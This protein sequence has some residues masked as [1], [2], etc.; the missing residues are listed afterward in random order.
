MEA[1][2]NENDPY[3]VR[4]LGNL[5]SG[6]HIANGRVDGRSIGEVGGE[7]VGG[8]QAHFFAGIGV[9][10]YALRL[11]GVPDDFPVWTGSCPCQ[12]FSCAGRGLGVSDERHLWPEW[13]RL[14]RKCRPSLVFGEQVA[15]KDGLA[16]LDS[17]HD[18][19]E[20]EGYAVGAA[21]LCAPGVG[22]PHKRSRI[23]FVAH[24]NLKGG[25]GLVALGGACEARPWGRFGEA[26]LQRLIDAPTRNGD[27]WP[28][29]IIRKVDDGPSKR[30]GRLH[31]YGNSIVAP[32]AAEFIRASIEAIDSLT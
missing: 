19:L 31:A 5:V 25:K 15:S 30:V 23:Y 27:L 17:V 4:W 32:L 28:Q 13:F 14:I 2:Y 6:G 12:P 9:W 26:D 24:P 18:D 7:E 29:P 20:G 16:W 8:G 1:Y 3:A 22:A 10:S 11:A 21:V